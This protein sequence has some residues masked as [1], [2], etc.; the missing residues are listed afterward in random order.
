MG[1]EVAGVYLRVVGCLRFA[2]L[3]LGWTLV[4]WFGAGLLTA[5]LLPSK[6]VG[7]TPGFF[8]PADGGWFVCGGLF[9]SLIA[10]FTHA[11]Y[12]AGTHDDRPRS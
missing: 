9:L 6:S 4:G 10:G 11:I 3:V 1:V 12:D 7:D 2:G 8:I 5:L